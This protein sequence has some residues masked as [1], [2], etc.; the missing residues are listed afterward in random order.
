M[1][2]PFRMTAQAGFRAVDVTRDLGGKFLRRWERVV[3]P[4]AL[5]RIKDALVV[6]GLTSVDFKVLAASLCG[7]VR[8]NHFELW[9]GKGSG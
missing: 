4:E 7:K 8:Y 6:I 2:H 5:D 1:T 9:L 3:A